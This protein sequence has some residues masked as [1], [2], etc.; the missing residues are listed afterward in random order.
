MKVFPIERLPDAGRTLMRL[1]VSLVLFNLFPL[2][3]LWGVLVRD[4]R[5]YG[6]SLSYWEILSSIGG[7]ISVAILVG[8][9]AAI[10]MFAWLQLRSRSV[11]AD[12]GGAAWMSIHGWE[13]EVEK[14]PQRGLTPVSEAIGVTVVTAMCA[15]VAPLAVM[16]V[17]MCWSVGRTL[18]N[19]SELSAQCPGLFG[20]YWLLHATALLCFDNLWAGALLVIAGVLV[21]EGLMHVSLKRK[22]ELMLR[23]DLTS[24]SRRVGAS[25]TDSFQSET[26]SPKDRT[27]SCFYISKLGQLPHDNE[28]T[29]KGASWCAIVVGWSTYCF[30][31]L[32]VPF[33]RVSSTYE[34]SIPPSQF[35]GGMVL[36]FIAVAGL[37]QTIEIYDL[38]VW[39]PRLSLLTRLQLFRPVVWSYDRAFVPLV[40]VGGIGIV[41]LA[42]VKNETPA[43]F[44]VLSFVAVLI[45]LRGRVNPEEWQMTSD[46]RLD[47]SFLRERRELNRRRRR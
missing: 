33:E 30:T 32:L 13:G 24:F 45:L 42:F 8:N 2:I 22:A 21:S 29:W 25:L 14:L 6:D 11:L 47:P 44:G 38:R 7:V 34:E 27:R 17:P 39:R 1:L 20:V 41:N 15:L 40:V 3:V 35:A 43:V 26:S 4:A 23:T 5:R 36:L 10:L 16:L 37:M 12:D 18:F 46:S 31:T 19:C 9:S 28:F